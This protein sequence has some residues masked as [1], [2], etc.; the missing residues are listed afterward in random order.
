MALQAI[1]DAEA[2]THAGEIQYLQYCAEKCFLVAEMQ[3]EIHKINPVVVPDKPVFTE[4]ITE[5]E[6]SFLPSCL[7]KDIQAETRTFLEEKLLSP[8]KV[9]SSLTTHT[10]GFFLRHWIVINKGFI[11]D[12]DLFTRVQHRVSKIY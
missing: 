9:R 8:I 5:Q 3:L 7:V 4:V 1:R 10:T 12:V 11:K 6:E 2:N